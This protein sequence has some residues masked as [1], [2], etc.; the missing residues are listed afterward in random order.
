MFIKILIKYQYILAFLAL[1][2]GCN[3]YGLYSSRG[4]RKE[5]DAE[6]KKC[7]NLIPVW[8][9]CE[10]N[11]AVTA[12][13]CRPW[14]CSPSKALLSMGVHFEKNDDFYF[15]HDNPAITDK[16][17]IDHICK[18][19]KNSV[20]N[21]YP[22]LYQDTLRRLVFTY[23]QK[24]SARLS[25]LLSNIKETYYNTTKTVIYAGL[26]NARSI[27]DIVESD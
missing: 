3:S 6:I 12:A 19:V 9:I 8:A 27:S 20:F 4:L 24:N 18:E 15:F 21:R 5:I 16:K 1:S 23:R 17:V 26:H 11:K 25:F 10:L 2:I 14:K 7:E 22:T 13:L